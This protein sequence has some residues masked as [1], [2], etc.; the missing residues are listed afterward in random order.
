MVRYGLKPFNF[1]PGSNHDSKT[2]PEVR[3]NFVGLLDNSLFPCSCSHRRHLSPSRRSRP[4]D[5]E[6]QCRIKG[7]SSSGAGGVDTLVGA[8]E[9][10]A[11]LSEARRR[12]R[13]CTTRRTD[14]NGR[15]RHMRCIAL[16]TTAPLNHSFTSC[17]RRQRAGSST[18]PFDMNVGGNMVWNCCLPIG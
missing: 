1:Q 6:P 8:A 12:S 4:R 7:E 18:R 10:H 5:A 13:A 17:S 11:Q 3:S 2:V 14:E 16:L 9:D 15:R